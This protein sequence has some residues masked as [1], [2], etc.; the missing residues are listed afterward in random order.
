MI[1]KDIINKISLKYTAISSYLSEK[2][3]RIWSATEARSL[4]YGGISAVAVATSISR[5]TIHAGLNEL[6]VKPENSM[7]D[8]KSGGGRKSILLKSPKLLSE[9]ECLLEPATRG[10]PESAL[11]WT[12]KSV[13]NLFN[14]LNLKGYKISPR[15]V[16]N[17]LAVL[18]YSLQSNNKRYEGTNHPDRNEQFEYIYKKVKIFQK[19]SNPII[20]VDAKKKELVGKFKN[21]GREWKPKGKPENVNVYDFPDPKKPKAAPYGVDDERN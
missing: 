11:K 8:R 19:T 21:N 6:D 1:S 3:R 15:S 18:G 14:E 10:D 2:S 9:L 4:G 20:S 7:L 17:L 13:K 12:C 5:P 16:C